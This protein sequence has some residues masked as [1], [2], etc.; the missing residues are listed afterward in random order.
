[1]H[2]DHRRL[3]RALPTFAKGDEGRRDRGAVELFF[4]HAGSVKARPDRCACEL[5]LDAVAA[6][7]CGRGVTGFVPEPKGF[8][9]GTDQATHERPL[10]EHSQSLYRTPLPMRRPCPGIYAVGIVRGSTC[11]FGRQAVRNVAR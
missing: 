1:M 2:T 7:V 9:A 10:R 5:G 8:L 11:C 3:R 4:V 6:P